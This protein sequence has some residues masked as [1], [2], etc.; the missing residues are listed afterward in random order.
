MSRAVG[1]TVADAD[2]LAASMKSGAVN[3]AT[4]VVLQGQAGRVASMKG[5]AGKTPRPV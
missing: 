1:T 2:V 5:G 4:Q 3:A